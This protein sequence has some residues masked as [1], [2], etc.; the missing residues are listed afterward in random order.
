MPDRHYASGQPAKTGPSTEGQG[1]IL[2]LFR[3]AVKDPS[4]CSGRNWFADLSGGS[5]A[6]LDTVQSH[7]ER[8]SGTTH[9][10]RK[11]YLLP[12][13]N[14]EDG[15]DLIPLKEFNEGNFSRGIE[16]NQGRFSRG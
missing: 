13:K 8:S 7:R 15:V 16:T 9:D 4:Q 14:L 10:Y 5:E 3:T 12:S 6:S 2:F 11:D 1:Y